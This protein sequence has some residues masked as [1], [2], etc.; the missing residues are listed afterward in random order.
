MATLKLIIAFDVKEVVI[1]HDQGAQNIVRSLLNKNP[2]MRLGC[3]KGDAQD[4]QGNA[5][6]SRLDWNLLKLRKYKPPYKP[7]LDL[8]KQRLKMLPD[9]TDDVGKVPTNKDMI[10]LFEDF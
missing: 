8:V 4:V 9:S 5:W 7:E 10:K 3:G 6:F 2:N 1:K